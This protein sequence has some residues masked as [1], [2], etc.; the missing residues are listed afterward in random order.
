MSRTAATSSASSIS[1]CWSIAPPRASPSWPRPKA[2]WRSKR[3]PRSTPEKILKVAI[4]PGDRHPALPHPQDRLLPRPRRQ[5]DRLGLE[6]H[7]RRST[8][9]STRS[10][11]R[12][13]RSTRWSS[14]AP[15]TC[16]RSDAK[17][18]FD[19][20]ALFR[21]KDDRGAARS[22]RGGSGRARGRQA[23]PQ[24][25]QARRQSIGC[26]V[27]GAGLAMATMDII[28]LYGGAPANFLDVGGG[29][30]KERVTTRLQD[31]PLR[32]QRRRH[33][34]QHLRRHHALRRHRRRRGRRGARGLR[35]TCRW[36]CAWKAPTSS[37]ARRS[38]RNRA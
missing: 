29:A 2:A 10:T 7:H 35:C 30:T 36:W 8:A 38:W 21:H 22:R 6:V 32:P 17:V 4:D 13:S 25:H 9:P 16:W 5:P 1:A 24:L 20:N 26:M 28:K 18:N 14:P 33:P 3:S 11:A 19:D 23:Q 34:G 37:W 15:A 12:S 31:H 27:N